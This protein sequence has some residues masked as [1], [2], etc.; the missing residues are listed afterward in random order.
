MQK[1]KKNLNPIPPT[2]RGKKRYVKF[3]LISDTALNEKDVWHSLRET[4]FSLFGDF[5]SASL[6][7]WPV[8]WYAQ[9]NEGILRCSLEGMQSAKLAVIFVQS[10]G[11]KKVV[12]LVISVSGSVRKLKN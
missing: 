5:G 10:V 2:L 12:P 11:G 6:K 8:K 3:S 4:V 9:K 1:T 7:I